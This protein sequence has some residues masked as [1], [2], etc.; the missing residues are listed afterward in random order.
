MR[1][2][3]EGSTMTE[4][5]SS[6]LGEAVL[7][8]HRVKT[9]VIATVV[10][11]CSL[12][13][14]QA[15]GATTGASATQTSATQTSA[16]QTG[17]TQ[18]GA[19]PLVR[20]SA[21]P[22]A[23]LSE[24]PP[25][26]RAKYT[27][28]TYP[29]PI[30]YRDPA[31]GTIG[32]AM[33][34]RAADDPVHRIGSLFLNPGGP[35]GSGFGLPIPLAGLL[36]AVIAQRF[37]LVG[38]DPRGVQRSAPLRCFTTNEEA[39]AVFSRIIDVPVTR[40]EIAST[41]RAYRDSTDACAA[42][43]GPLLQHMSTLDV[44][45]DLDR[46]RQG[47]GDKRLNYLGFSYGS[48]LG[49]TYVNLYPQRARAIVL[50]GNVDPQLRTRDGLE[51]L[52]QR[53][54]GQE[55]VVD[56][57]LQRCADVGPHCAFSGG[58]PRAKFAEIRERLRQGPVTVPGI[59]ELTL[60]RFT[61]AVAGN[62]YQSQVYADLA[63]G[64]QSVYETIHPGVTAA[65]SGA[66]AFANSSRNGLADTPYTGDESGLGVN[67]TDE[68]FPRTQA[69]FPI[70]A[71]RW[72]RESP[73]VGRAHAFSQVACATW[74][75]RQPDR[76]GGPWNRRTANPVLLFGNYHDPATN[77][78]F[79]LRMAAELGSARLVSVDAFGHT[80]LGDS[81]CADDIAARYLVDLVVPAEGTVCQPNSQP[82]E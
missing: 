28:A 15:A 16:T 54:A 41:L 5:M 33:L 44:A 7:M 82:F 36:P 50:D 19:A 69:V 52:R 20:W 14:G 11:A 67:C 57:F 75:T 59:G 51:Y 25:A 73:T 10:A 45:R 13:S 4:S 53:A 6:S 64:L 70:A 66:G 47:V 43:A 22:D 63:A 74:P 34:R 27:C 18:T 35:G 23:E 56:A 81:A 77:Y 80:I 30:D 76:Y 12:L 17:A 38:F 31:A 72:E 1:Y 32:L 49:A 3:R 21:C 78:G 68:P 79:N 9:A 39:E 8:N 42:N 62:L 65:S 24:V 55:A 46:M 26:D 60:S 58:D 40:A 48:L 2:G 29:V 71:Q 61:S 37:D